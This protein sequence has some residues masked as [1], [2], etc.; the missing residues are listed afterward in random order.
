[1]LQ[2]HGLASWAVFQLTYFHLNIS[3]VYRK[4]KN[5]WGI[6]EN[7]SIA[8]KILVRNN[9]FC[10]TLNYF[11]GKPKQIPSCENDLLRYH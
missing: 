3:T 11:F 7:Q 6:S 2:S 9:V 10:V 5:F 8:K 1:M 4:K